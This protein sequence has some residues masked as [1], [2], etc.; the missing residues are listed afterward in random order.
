MAQI[1]LGISLFRGVVRKFLHISE[2][3]RRLFKGGVLSKVLNL[4]YG[5][6][7]DILYRVCNR[8]SV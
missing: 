6:P 5:E 7:V 8:Y 1:P 4:Q 3:M 2:P